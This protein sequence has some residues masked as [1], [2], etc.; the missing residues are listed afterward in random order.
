MSDKVAIVGA[1]HAGVA[2]A[3]VLKA[4]GLAV[5]LFTAENTLPY[6]RPRLIAV[7]FGQ[8]EPDAIAI[9]PASFYADGIN[10]I[11]RTV[12]SPDELKD[13]AGVILTQGSVPFV[14]P[15]EGDRARLHTLWNVQDAMRIR[16]KIRQ[17]A[18]LTVIG[19]GVLGLESAL[20]AAMAGLKVTVIESSALAGG[21]LGPACS[22]V[23]EETLEAKG[24]TLRVGACVAK[25][26]A[27]GIRLGDGTLV[28]D[29]LLLCSTGARGVTAL[30]EA[31][32]AKADCGLLTNPDLSFAPMRY[33]AGDLARPT[34]A[35][36][37]CA[38]RRATAM[39]T[40]AAQNLDRPC[41]AAFHEG[42][43]HRIPY[44]WLLPRR[45]PGRTP[46]R[47]RLQGRRDSNHSL[48]RESPRRPPF[49]RYPRRLRRLGETDSCLRW[50]LPSITFPRAPG[51]G[52]SFWVPAPRSAYR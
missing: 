36:P 47:R 39:G 45:Q 22:K 40:L 46:H 48:Q 10:L 16:A 31:L 27:N 17:G 35:R 18:R 25:I 13:Y 26:E 43:G 19:G 32:G 4:A 34:E 2:A 15:F 9:K 37:V 29:D 12:T 3:A 30:G 7:A 11:H 50:A 51:S 21:I 41:P 49:C 42:R 23:L 5:D 8:A 1:G 24:I 44:V 14:P 33:A 28:E 38:V 6:F 20:R 52:P